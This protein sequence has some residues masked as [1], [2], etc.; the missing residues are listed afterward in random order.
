MPT[1]M[2]GHLCSA[3]LEVEERENIPQSIKLKV[4]LFQN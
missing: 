1:P 4:M 3:T 2:F